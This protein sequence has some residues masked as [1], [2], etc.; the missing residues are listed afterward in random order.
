LLYIE[1]QDRKTIRPYTGIKRSE[2]RIRDLET[3]Q[4]L[5]TYKDA[6]R[7]EEVYKEIKT[8]LC[9]S[10]V[11]S[12]SPHQENPSLKFYVPERTIYS[13]PKE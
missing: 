11:I 1:D 8:A 5:G 7:T 2:V 13:M 12:V 3:T 9:N 10:E 4:L 6:Q